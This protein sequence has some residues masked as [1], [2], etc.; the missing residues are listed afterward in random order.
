MGN[1]NPFFFST[2]L[3]FKYLEGFCEIC[4]TEC[5]ERK[6]TERL[7]RHCMVG[8]FVEGGTLFLLDS[9]WQRRKSRTFSRMG[10]YDSLA[11]AD[12]DDTDR[13]QI[14]E[15]NEGTSPKTELS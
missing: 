9:P 6:D 1:W 7:E 3:F 8:E 13:L 10:V 14:T 15:P 5:M 2:P 12:A 11:L 4:I